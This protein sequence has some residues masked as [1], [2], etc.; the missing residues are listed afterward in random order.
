M[1]ELYNLKI[2]QCIH[3]RFHLLRCR[4][5]SRIFKRFDGVWCVIHRY[6]KLRFTSAIKAVWT[7]KPYLD[8]MYACILLYIGLGSYL[9]VFYVH[10]HFHLVR[11]FYTGQQRHRLYMRRIREHIHRLGFY[12]LI[13]HLTQQL[14]VAGK[15]SRIA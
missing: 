11:S 3:Y 5:S 12:E 2:F 6:P 8:S 4:M 13:S 14:D 15:C 10:F 9:A 1:Y 7:L